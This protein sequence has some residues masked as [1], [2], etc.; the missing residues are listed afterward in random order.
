MRDTTPYLDSTKTLFL[1]S[2]YFV[3]N[4]KI[5]DEKEYQR[6]IEKTEEVFKMYKGKYLVVD[7]TPEVLEG[8]W[9]YTR[10]VIIEFESK[11]E[12]E[13]WYNS[14][15]YREIL[16]YRLNAAECDSILAKGL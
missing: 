13:N 9:D 4:I 6:Y 2:Y 16:K 14:A 7:N 15:E 11:T 1:M 12:F 5:N 8:N 3:A 10:T